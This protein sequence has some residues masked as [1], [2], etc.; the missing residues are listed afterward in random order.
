[1]KSEIRTAW[2]ETAK[3]WVSAATSKGIVLGTT[4]ACLSEVTNFSA[5]PPSVAPKP[6]KDKWLQILVRPLRH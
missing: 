5:S 1:L 4:I 2:N 3:G 6:H